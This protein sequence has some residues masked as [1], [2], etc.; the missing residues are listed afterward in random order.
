MLIANSP[1]QTDGCCDIGMLEVVTNEP[2]RNCP[3]VLSSQPLSYEQGTGVI[4]D[5]RHEAVSRD[6]LML[7]LIRSQ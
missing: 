6:R 3:T 1:A 4:D 5:A 7:I 2:K